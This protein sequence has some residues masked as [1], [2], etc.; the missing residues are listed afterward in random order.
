M[1]QIHYVLQLTNSELNLPNMTNSI[2]RAKMI[3][4]ISKSADYTIVEIENCRTMCGRIDWDELIE[5]DYELYARVIEALLKM[6]LI[7]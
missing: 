2:T 1:V 4:R 6:H 3:V 7:K 5:E